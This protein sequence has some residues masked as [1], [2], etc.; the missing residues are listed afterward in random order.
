MNN[1][2]LTIVVLV[3]AGLAALGAGIGSYVA[4]QAGSEP[5]TPDG[6]LWPNPKTF[7][8]VTLYDHNGD[9]FTTADFKDQW[10]LVFFGFTHCPDIC[11]NT[12]SQLDRLQKQLADNG[13][14]DSELQVVFIS[15]DPE[16]DTPERLAEYV[17]YFNRDFVGASGDKEAIDRLTRS[18]GAVYHIAE[19]D[20]DGDYQVDHSA[21]VF[22][23]DPQARMVS[24]FTTPHEVP[25]MREQFVAIHDFIEQQA[26]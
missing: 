12:L 16:R 4:Q 11:P 19:A 15:V 26:L 23:F 10:S 5:D 6:L 17:E 22:L 24:V 3:L 9:D 14:D 20:E 18:I 8:D 21:S 1:Q 25:S 13:I 7:P 2:R